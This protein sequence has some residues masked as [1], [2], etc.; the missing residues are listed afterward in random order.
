MLAHPDCPC[1][2]ASLAELNVAMARVPTGLTAYIVFSKPGATPEQVRASDLWTRALRMPGVHPI[3]DADGSL[4]ARLDGKVSGQT[5]LYGPDGRL[6]FNGGITGGRG[7]EGDNFGMTS[8][9][10][11]ALGK[12]ADVGSAPVFGCA[13]AAPASLSAREQGS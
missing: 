4:T 8:I 11:H 7:H 5:L 10:E 12:R 6:V 1:S 3:H 2:T 13:L 9:V